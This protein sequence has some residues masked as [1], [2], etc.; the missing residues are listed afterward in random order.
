MQCRMNGGQDRRDDGAGKGDIKETRQI[1]LRQP[2][3]DLLGIGT[4]GNSRGAASPKNT[5]TR[6]AMR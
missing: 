6:P 1:G 4:P 2:R 5:G 3:D